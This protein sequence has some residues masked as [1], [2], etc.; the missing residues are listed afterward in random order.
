[1]ANVIIYYRFQTLI[2]SLT[3]ITISIAL[4]ALFYY[5]RKLT[6][7]RWVVKAVNAAEKMFPEPGSSQEK[8]DWVVN[9]LKENNFTVNVSDEVVDALIESAVNT[10]NIQQG[11]CVDSGDVKK[12]LSLKKQL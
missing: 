8:K 10:M 5:I 11:K 6:L 12:Q 2:D 1:M 3:L 9:F 7:E 4:Y